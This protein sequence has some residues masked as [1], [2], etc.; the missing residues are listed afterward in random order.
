VQPGRRVLKRRSRVFVAFERAILRAGMSVIAFFIER[1]L[2]KAIRKGSV[3]P[4]PRTAAEAEEWP[5]PQG[6]LSTGT[7]Q[8][9]DQAER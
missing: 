5:T 6:Q 1:R 7:H 8:V 3:E 9:R 4:A 2:L